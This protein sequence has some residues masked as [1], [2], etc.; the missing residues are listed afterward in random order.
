MLISHNGNKE[1]NLSLHQD[2]A[3]KASSD[4]ENAVYIWDFGDGTQLNGT[5]VSY[6]YNSSGRFNISVTGKNEVSETRKEISVVVLA[7]ITGLSVN[8]SLVNVPLNTS[9]HFEAHFDQGDDVRYSWILCDQCTSIQGTHT[10]FYTFRSVGTFNVIVI[11]ENYICTVQ[12]S[13]SIF[14]QRE[15]EGLQIVA[16]E[17]IEGYCFATNRVLHLQASLKEG[18]NMTFSWNLLR[19][20]ENY[21]Y[22]L[23]GKTIDLN[24]STPGPCAVLLKATAC[25]ASWL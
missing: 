4:S 1:N 6:T 17:L 13:I 10:M 11:A 14:V 22:N 16:D 15:L 23:T 8:S 24:F 20:H 9:V 2:Y 21:N 7:P 25:L 3:F 5:N 19:E 18:T 12:S